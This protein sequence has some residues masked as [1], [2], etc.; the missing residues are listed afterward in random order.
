MSAQTSIAYPA[1]YVGKE[2]WQRQLGLIRSAVTHLGAKEVAYTLDIGATHLSDAIHER[3]R[4]VW[5]GHWTHVLKAMLAAKHDDTA[6]ELLRAIAEIDLAT[7]PYALTEQ[8]E[9]TPEQENAI[10]RRELLAFGSAGKTALERI[11][12]GRR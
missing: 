1:D 6:T 9:L 4:K 2:A 5:H 12:R 7:T 8:V 11:K 3:E 10:L